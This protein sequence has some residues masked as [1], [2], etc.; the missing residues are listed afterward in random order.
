MAVWDVDLTT[1]AGANTAAYQ[2]ALACFVFCGMAVLGTVMLGAT[3][4]FTTINGI[5]AMIGAGGEAL[6]ALIAGLRLRAGKG[7]Y[8]GIAAAVLLVLEMVVK[9]ISLSI[10]GLLLSGVVL[11]VMIN[12]IRGAWALKRSTGFA[13]DDAEVF[14]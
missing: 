12:G 5:S 1:R 13:E 9:L 4:G 3:A 11:L 7:A 6:I 14:G 10:P 2:G 8:W